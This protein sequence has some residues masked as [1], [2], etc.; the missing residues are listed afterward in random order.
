MLVLGLPALTQ[1]ADISMG[2]HIPRSLCGIGVG[3]LHIDELGNLQVSGSSAKATESGWA[4][5]SS[6][7]AA[8]A[9]PGGLAPNGV[10]AEGPSHPLCWSLLVGTMQGHVLHVFP[11]AKGASAAGQPPGDSSQ[12][13]SIT[14]DGVDGPPWAWNLRVGSLPVTLQKVQAAG[15]LGVEATV[16]ASSDGGVLLELARGGHGMGGQQ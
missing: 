2:T 14:V 5:S 6:L 16:Y 1:L 9:A 8:C 7:Q 11:F 12:G 15:K 4:T 10:V 13:A 3:G